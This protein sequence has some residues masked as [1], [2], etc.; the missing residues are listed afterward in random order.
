MKR[1]LPVMIAL[2]ALTGCALEPGELSPAGGTLPITG[3][4]NS[5]SYTAPAPAKNLAPIEASPSPSPVVQET[6]GAVSRQNCYDMEA[7][8]LREGRRITLVRV[9]RS[10]NPGATLQYTCIFEGEDADQGYFED[11]RY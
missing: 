11:K 7:K 5:G 3:G 2:I 4:G 9:E 8:F 10:T 6:H 1:F